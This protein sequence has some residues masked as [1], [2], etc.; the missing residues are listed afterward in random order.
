[1]LSVKIFSVILVYPRIVPTDLDDLF[2]V[3]SYCFTP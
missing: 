3:P 1:M 2:A